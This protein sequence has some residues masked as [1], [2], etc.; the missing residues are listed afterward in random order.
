[1]NMQAQ[2]NRR[3]QILIAAR[4][5][6]ACEGYTKASIKKIAAQ[7]DLN[8]PALIYWYFSNKAELFAAVLSEA[9]LMLHEVSSNNIL[10]DLTPQEALEILARRFIETFACPSNK[11]IFR[12]LISESVNNVEVSNHF[13]ETVILP[14]KN[15]LVPY[16]QRKIDEHLLRV[17]DPEISTRAFIGTLVHYIFVDEIF[18]QLWNDPHCPDQFIAEIVR[19]FLDGLT[20]VEV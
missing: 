11:R 20:A 9:S 13:A 8:S 3:D 15:Y 10:E 2:A 19:I 17:H 12:I 1:M 7:A 18:P 16:F 14:I 4:D 5:V 6:F